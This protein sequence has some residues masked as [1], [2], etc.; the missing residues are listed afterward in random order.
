[1]SAFGAKQTSIGL[2]VMSAYDPNQ[3]S[4]TLSKGSFDSIVWFLGCGARAAPICIGRNELQIDIPDVV[5]E[6]RAAFERHEQAL[7]TN[8]VATLDGMFR[9]DPRTIR[10]GQSENSYGYKEIEAFRRLVR[11]LG[12]PEPFQRP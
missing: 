8:D 3:T 1:M 7:V 12:L 5:A 9:N 10:Y 2:T 11:P 6:V 4:A